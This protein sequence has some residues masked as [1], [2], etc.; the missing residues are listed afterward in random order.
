MANASANKLANNHVANVLQRRIGHRVAYVAI[1]TARTHAPATQ[2]RQHRTN[3]SGLIPRKGRSERSFAHPLKKLTKSLG[4]RSPEWLL[5]LLLRV[6][7]A[8]MFLRISH[9]AE[10]NP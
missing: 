5:P 9:S 8:K 4:V 6:D 1:N 10:T 3:V 7:S 2:Q